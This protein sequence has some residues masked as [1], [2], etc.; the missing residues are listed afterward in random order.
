MSTPVRCQ[1]VVMLPD[2]AARSVY[3]IRQRYDATMAD[4]IGAH[5]TV[6][7][8]VDDPEA[9]DRQLAEV[10]PSCAPF[11]LE[12]GRPTCWTDAPAGG[13]YLPVDDRVGALSDLRG[14]LQGDGARVQGSRRYLPHVTLVHHRTATIDGAEQAWQDLL[15]TPPDIASIEVDA[16]RSVRFEG[17]RWQPVGSFPLGG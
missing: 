4:R 5:I 9:L 8:D 1:A 14:Q 15:R 16:I 2:A 10:T 13:I 17:D 7:Y 12:L 11:T 6:L 3:A